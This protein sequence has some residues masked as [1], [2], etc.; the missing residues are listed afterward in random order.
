MTFEAEDH[1]LL[2]GF[3]SIYGRIESGACRVHAGKYKFENAYSL[4]SQ[5]PHSDLPDQDLHLGINRTR[6]E[7]SFFLKIGLP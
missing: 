6:D 3:G 5:V 4:C 2:R 7:I 1:L